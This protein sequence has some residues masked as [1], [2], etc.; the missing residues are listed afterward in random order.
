MQDLAGL[1][2]HEGETED[3]GNRRN[4]QE[5]LVP[6]TS[7]NFPVGFHSP[8]RTIKQVCMNVLSIYENL[9]FEL[10]CVIACKYLCK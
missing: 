2:G 10:A 7:V 3:N 6:G 4:G 1:L 5:C 9:V 8:Y